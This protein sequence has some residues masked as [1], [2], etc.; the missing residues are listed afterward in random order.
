MRVSFLLC[1]RQ[2]WLD[3]S[4]LAF[5]IRITRVFQAFSYLL[6][7]LFGFVNLLLACN[8]DWST[9]VFLRF[10]H[11]LLFQFFYC[12]RPE[13]WLPRTIWLLLSSRKLILSFLPFLS[14]FIEYLV[15]LEIN[16]VLECCC[17]SLEQI[18][19]RIIH[20]F[21]Q[22]LAKI[23]FFVNMLLSLD[24]ITRMQI[25]IVVKVHESEHELCSIKRILRFKKWHIKMF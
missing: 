18:L 6:L 12:T 17:L 2:Y 1:I 4:L 14:Q 22:F 16:F 10:V 25:S 11:W 13:M 21:L 23:W 5:A 8:K 7:E 9:L 15:L 24:H 3:L 20:N 19:E